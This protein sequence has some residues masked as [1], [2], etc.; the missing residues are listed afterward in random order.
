M[1]DQFEQVFGVREFEAAGEQFKLNATPVSLRGVL[2]WG[3][4]P[5]SLAPSTDPNWMR[6]E[7]AF[8]KARG[9]T[10]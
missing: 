4:S 5:P 2:N 9:L 6:D 10:S 8:A 3:Y 7:I 1:V